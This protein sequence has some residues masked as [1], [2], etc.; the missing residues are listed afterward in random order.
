M[1]AKCLPLCS[2][3]VEASDGS[4][5]KKKICCSGRV[6]FFSSL[7]PY[8]LEKN[9]I[10]QFDMSQ[11]LMLK[12]TDHI[13]YPCQPI[14]GPGKKVQSVLFKRLVKIQSYWYWAV[15]GACYMGMKYKISCYWWTV[16][17][18]PSC[19]V[20]ALQSVQQAAANAALIWF[21]GSVWKRK[22]RV[23]DRLPVG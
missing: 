23:S 15:I 20:C 2:C 5:T 8:L 10:W 12:P 6:H 22:L 17:R 21:G 11:M 16:G 19:W 13:F 18:L 7:P 3:G 9:N 4:W 14:R 1:P